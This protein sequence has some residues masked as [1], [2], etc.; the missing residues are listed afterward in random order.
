MKILYPAVLS[1]MLFSCR[2]IED[3][4]CD[5]SFIGVWRVDT[6]GLYINYKN[7]IQKRNW[8]NIQLIA[9]SNGTFKFNSTDKYLKQC[10]GKWSATYNTEDNVCVLNYKENYYSR[11]ISVLSGFD[12]N[13]IFEDSTQFEIPF[14]KE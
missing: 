10:E 7:I 1:M 12:I 9:D 11:Y 4:H 3:K 6:T 8:L 14:K 5:Q 2:T 13:G